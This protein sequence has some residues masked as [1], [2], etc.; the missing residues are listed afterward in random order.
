M[1]HEMIT[2]DT[3]GHRSPAMAAGCLIDIIADGPDCSGTDHSCVPRLQRR[4]R[5]LSPSSSEAINYTVSLNF[6]PWALLHRV[7]SCRPSTIPGPPC[8]GRYNYQPCKR[9]KDDELDRCAIT[10]PNVSVTTFW[11]NTWAQDYYLSKGYLKLENTSSGTLKVV[12][13]TK[14]KSAKELAGL[15][16]KK[17]S[18]KQQTG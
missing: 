7:H 16:A 17:P 6:E 9:G 18:A 13:A 1:T 14:T 8:T 3:D 15:A 10:M 5:D 4:A 2:T 12:R 11:T